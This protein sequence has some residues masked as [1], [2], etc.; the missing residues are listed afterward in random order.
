NEKQTQKRTLLKLA[1][2]YEAELR[3]AHRAVETYLRV[4]ELD[5]KEPEALAALDRLYLGAGMYDE[6]VEILPRRIEISQDPDETIELH[7]RRGAIFSDALG[8]LDASLKSYQSV[9]DQ[10]S[11]NRRALE[12]QEGIYFRRE[13]WTKLYDTYEKLIDC[14]EG[15]DEMAE[16]Y[17]RMAR[18]AS[19]ALGQDEKAMDLLG[20]VLDIR[21]EDPA[22]LDA[23]AVL[24][25]RKDKWDELVEVIE[26]QVAVAPGDQ[27]QIALYKRLGRVWSEKLGRERSSLDA[28]LCADRLDPRDLETL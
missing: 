15:D 27:E 18:I 28:W 20:R 10:E 1:R 14:A 2:V 6:L 8:D 11:R 24:Y 13:D 21:G 16:I 22:A 26:R 9:L 19:D 3:D 5:A 12:A 25:T 7:F 17:A 4:L 23:L